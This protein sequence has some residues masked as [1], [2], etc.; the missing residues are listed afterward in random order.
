MFDKINTRKYSRALDKGLL[1][2]PGIPR[3]DFREP[4]A[5]DLNPERLLTH[6]HQTGKTDR[7]IGEEGSHVSTGM[8]AGNSMTRYGP[9]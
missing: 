7:G 1:V 5:F 2:L 8:E 9:E 4:G 6:A 3:I